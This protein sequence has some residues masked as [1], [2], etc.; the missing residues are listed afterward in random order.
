M[1]ARNAWSPEETIALIEV[2][3]D[4]DIEGQLS[5]IHRN[6]PVMGRVAEL[7][8]DRGYER[9]GP[10]C[11]TKMKTLKSDYKNIKHLNNRSGRGPAIGNRV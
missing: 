10:Q 2:W 5:G 9:T 7:L 3:R 1:A 6:I 11:R 8:R 4:E